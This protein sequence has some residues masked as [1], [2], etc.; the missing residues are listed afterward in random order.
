MAQYI[1]GKNLILQRLRGNTPVQ[2]LFLTQKNFEANKSLIEQ[3]KTPYE[4]LS[5]Q[6]V[7]KLV[8]GVHQGMVALIESYK[9]YSLEDLIHSLDLSRQ[10]HIL[11]LCDQLEDPHNLGAILRTADAVGVSGVIIGKHR[12]IGL[13]QTVAKVSTGAIETI[14]VSEVTNLAKSCAYLKQQGFWIIGADNNE[15]IDY[16]EMPRDRN[17]VLVVGSE[18]KGIS[19]LV[20]KQCDYL[21]KIPMY[22]TVN[23]LNVSVATGILL[24]ELVRNK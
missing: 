20:K 11:V 12:S 23:S 24:Y 13:T 16:R 10:D 4:V 2:K 17:L 1:Y 7:D 21:V 15:T 6:A 3:S 19:P 18:G 22:G 9:T 8:N 14:P 5:I